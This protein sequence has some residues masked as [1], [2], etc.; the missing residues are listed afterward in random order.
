MIDSPIS[1]VS[2]FVS[3]DNLKSSFTLSNCS[4]SAFRS[5]LFFNLCFSLWR[6]FFYTTVKIS[7]AHQNGPSQI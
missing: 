4:D 7:R 2:A 3:W 1:K 6:R 5:S